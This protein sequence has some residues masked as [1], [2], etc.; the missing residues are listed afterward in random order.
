[1]FPLSLIWRDQGPHD[2]HQAWRKPYV[3]PEQRWLRAGVA[4]RNLALGGDTPTCP[5]WVKRNPGASTPR[6]E[7]AT[8]YNILLSAQTV[9]WPQHTLVQK[10]QRQGRPS[11]PVCPAQA[12]RTENPQ[13][14]PTL[15][16]CTGR[17]CREGN[18]SVSPSEAWPSLLPL[19]PTVPFLH[20]SLH[21]PNHQR[22]LEAQLL[23]QP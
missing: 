10:K 18:C 6:Q 22:C 3:R 4:R 14:V 17:G 7:G 15:H 9:C 11:A 8:V 20:L 1:M 23:P 21:F 13:P 5:G 19:E 2:T 12:N 16:S